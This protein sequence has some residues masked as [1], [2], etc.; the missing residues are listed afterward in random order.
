VFVSLSRFR[1]NKTH[2]L[3]LFRSPEF[4]SLG[5]TP[6]F[7]PLFQLFSLLHCRSA[8]QCGEFANAATHPR[9]SLGVRQS[10]IE[11]PPRVTALVVLLSL[12]M[13]LNRNNRG[14]PHQYPNIN[15]A[16]MNHANPHEQ[17][18]LIGSRRGEA[19]TKERIQSICKWMGIISVIALIILVLLHEAY[20]IAI[21]LASL[22]KRVAREKITMPFLDNGTKRN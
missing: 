2:R 12:T 3:R 10:C 15:P 22:N 5:R 20:T 17:T 19:D 1:E 8:T 14:P 18:P 16:G 6:Q 21:P 7:R 13:M 4:H 11:L 9:G